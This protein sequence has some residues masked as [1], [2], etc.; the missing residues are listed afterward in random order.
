MPMGPLPLAARSTFRH[1]ARE[2]HEK[3]HIST[4]RSTACTAPD[5]ARDPR[6]GR[7]ARAPRRWF[8]RTG[9]ALR[10]IF[11]R[12][13]I[14]D[15]TLLSLRQR[16]ACQHQERALGSGER[17]GRFAGQRSAMAAVP[18]FWRYVLHLPDTA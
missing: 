9:V 11:R 10:A 18:E 17:L 4:Q 8:T 13:P 3:G 16:T 6:V 1:V 5:Q 15:R 7:E 12:C 2:H 14:R